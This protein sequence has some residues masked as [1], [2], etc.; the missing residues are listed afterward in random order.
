[1]VDKIRIT[2]KDFSGVLKIKEY[3][4]ERIYWFSRQK[5]YR[6]FVLRNGTWSLTH[7]LASQAKKTKNKNVTI[8]GVTQMEFWPMHPAWLTQKSFSK[9]FADIAKES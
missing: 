7:D 3:C 2:L 6:H 8:E 1:M 5:Q 4:Q 9:A